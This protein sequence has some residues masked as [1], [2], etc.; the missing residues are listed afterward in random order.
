M[1]KLSII[2]PIYGVEQYLRKCVDS[3]LAQDIPSSEYEIILVD[4]GSPDECP[5]ICDEYEERAK[6]EDLRGKSIK[7]IHRENG[8][9]SA[10]RNSGIEVAQGEYVMFV[11]SDDYIE[12]NVLGGLLAQVERDNLDVLRY[13]LQYVNPQYEVYNPYKID[14]FKGNDYSEV[15]TDGVSFLNSRM[16]TQCYAWVFLIKRNLIIS[17]QNSAFSN[18]LKEKDNCLFTEGIYFEDTDWTPRMLCKAKCVASTNTVVYNYLMREGSITN[19]VNRSKQKKVLDD[20]MRLVETLQR[21]SKEFQEQGKDNRW[22]AKMIADTVISVISIIAVQ[23]YKERD[24]YLKHLKELD[25]YPIQS[26]HHK[27]RLINISPRLA[28]ALLHLKNR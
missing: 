9:L 6:S 10:A 24:S 16:N 13:R 2:V 19:A 3:L 21:Q 7:V 15:P 1:V 18:Q 4:D 11:D 26:K 17:D 28:V 5:Q 20:K 25:V 8:G 22:F 14:P 23:F 27:A 12:Q